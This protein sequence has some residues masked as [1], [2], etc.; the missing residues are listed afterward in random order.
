[1]K[2]VKSREDLERLALSRGASASI[3]ASRF[4]STATTV[5]AVVQQKPA[6]Q[7]VIPV[8]ELAPKAPDPTPSTPTQVEVKVDVSDLAGSV[9][10]MGESLA[11]IARDNAA[12]ME[13]VR[14]AMD[15]LAC[16]PVTTPADNSSI[17]EHAWKLKVNRD[18]RGFMETVDIT[19][20]A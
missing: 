19:R 8:A 7:L 4:N 14:K 16:A 6:E 20:V 2:T 11:C 1:M 17:R 15:R 3:G 5:A 13:E 9:A 18:T 10:A 12:V